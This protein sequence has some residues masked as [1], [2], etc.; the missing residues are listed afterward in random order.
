MGDRESLEFRNESKTLYDGA[1]SQKS[2]ILSDVT[3]TPVREKV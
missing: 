2:P 3:A 1:I